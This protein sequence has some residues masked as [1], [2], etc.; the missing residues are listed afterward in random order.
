MPGKE[1][2]RSQHVMPSLSVTVQKETGRHADD[3]A[4]DF[5]CHVSTINRL[6]ERH[7]VI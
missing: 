7:R 2:N 4:A 1:E 6:L 5:G 3:V